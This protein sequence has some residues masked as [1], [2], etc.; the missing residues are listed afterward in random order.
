MLIK[1]EDLVNKKKT[2]LIKTLKFIQTLDGGEL[3]INSVKLNKVI[4]STEFYKMQTLEKKETFAESIIDNDSG[5][6]KVFFNLGP[7]NDWKKILDDKS[8]K[9]IEVSFKKEMSEL[10][11]L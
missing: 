2:T 4:K 3:K 11:Y 7:Q 1:Y 6:R 8:R 5:I 10:G 9:K